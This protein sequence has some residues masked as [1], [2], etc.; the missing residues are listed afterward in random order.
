MN[1]KFQQFPYERQVFW[2]LGY[3]DTWILECMSSLWND[4]TMVLGYEA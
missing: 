4:G 1:K 2:I 3:M